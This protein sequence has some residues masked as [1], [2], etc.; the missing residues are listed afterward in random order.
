[1]LLWRQATRDR[2]ITLKFLTRTVDI[3]AGRNDTVGDVK[4]LIE[5][6]QGKPVA[7]LR[8]IGNGKELDDPTKKV[9]Y[10]DYFTEGSNI[11]HVVERLSS[12]PAPGPLVPWRRF[13]VLAPARRFP[14]QGIENYRNTCF[15]N[16]AF[17]LFRS[18]LP[19]YSNSDWLQIEKS[20]NEKHQQLLQDIDKMAESS[21][22]AREN[23]SGIATQLDIE[24]F[25]VNGLANPKQ[26]QQDDTQLALSRFLST[27]YPGYK[28]GVKKLTVVYKS[29]PSSV[30]R[31][32]YNICILKTGQQVQAAF[33]REFAY[34]NQSDPDNA[35]LISEERV[36]QDI[37]RKHILMF[38][39]DTEVRVP[40]CAHFN[41]NEYTLTA[42][43][44]H[45][46][47][48]GPG[49][50][51]QAGHYVAYVKCSD[52]RWWCCD[53]KNISNQTSSGQTHDWIAALQQQAYILLYD[54]LS[55]PC[56][57]LCTNAKCAVGSCDPNE[58][59]CNC[60]RQ[61]CPCK[62]T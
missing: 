25:W 16:A 35:N 41:N 21:P 13:V 54:N 8:L 12:A 40:L 11:L 61:H 36:W 57:A 1:M 58:N 18:M 47:A 2:D 50:H 46:G 34:F 23:L 42:F 15:I 26:I 37:N 20:L 5:N 28:T 24:N 17:Q 38:R 51:A 29:Q 53:D 3:K 52:N 48:R 32:V 39:P 14:P 56:H 33:D 22:I 60:G 55:N 19:R 49:G 10:N 4:Q 44:V 59:C 7:S 62:T 6:Q 31:E 30:K 27:L 45:Q 9:F 43:I